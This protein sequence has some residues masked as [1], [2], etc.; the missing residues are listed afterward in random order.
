MLTAELSVCFTDG[1]QRDSTGQP[2]IY[3]QGPSPVVPQGLSELE[4]DIG[5]IYR[6]ETE[7]L[8]ERLQELLHAA[9]AAEDQEESETQ[10]RK[11]QSEQSLGKSLSRLVHNCVWYSQDGECLKT[12]ASFL[13]G[14]RDLS[15]RFRTE[16]R[17]IDSMELGKGKAA[18]KLKTI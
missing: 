9:A 4:V 10:V 7:L 18:K 13:H 17:V 16:L 5:L 1:V 14:H 2:L 15:Q 11:K 3:E 8:E 12:L 6:W